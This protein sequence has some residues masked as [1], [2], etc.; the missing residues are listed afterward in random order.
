[1]SLG[2]AF[3]I[4]LCVNVM[5]TGS[6]TNVISF[7]TL[8]SYKI[9]IKY[10]VACIPLLYTASITRKQHSFRANCTLFRAERYRNTLVAPGDQG[11]T[12]CLPPIFRYMNFL[13]N[14]VFY[15]NTF[16]KIYLIKY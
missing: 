2:K 7:Y 3:M 16:K 15:F 5:V 12:M 10:S 11:V 6:V 9:A 1:M 13:L 8:L 4:R 14:F